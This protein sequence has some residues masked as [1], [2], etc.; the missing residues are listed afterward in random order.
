M[1]ENSFHLFLLLVVTNQK[2][3]QVGAED[4]AGRGQ[5]R[6]NILL[7]QFGD[8]EQE[9]DGHQDGVGQHQGKVLPPHAD[10]SERAEEDHHQTG[11]DQHFVVVFKFGLAQIAAGDQHE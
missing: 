3:V 11:K 6:A 8:L 4:D 9:G 5:K 10:D 1:G 7:G 2:G